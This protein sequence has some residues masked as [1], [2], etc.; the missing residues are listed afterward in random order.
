[1]LDYSRNPKTKLKHVNTFL[2]RYSTVEAQK[3]NKKNTQK[4]REINN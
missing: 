2:A 1:M 4:K 3:N